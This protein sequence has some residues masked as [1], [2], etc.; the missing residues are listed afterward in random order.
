[1]EAT[2]K[3]IFTL[4]LALLMLFPLLTACMTS[5]DSPKQTTGGDTEPLDTADPFD[6]GIEKTDYKERTFRIMC[7]WP[8]HWGKDSYNVE[9]DSGD[10]VVSAIYKRNRE[11]EAYFNIT[12]ESFTEGSTGST[13]ADLQPLVV[14]N[15][16]KI[17]LVTVGFYQSGKPLILQDLV[18]P[19][20]YVESINLEK[21]W[22]NK[23]IT[24][25]LAILDQYYYLVGDVNWF[26]MPE[27]AV[28]YFNKVVADKYEAKVGDLYQTVRDNEWTYDRCFAL[29][30]E[31]SA[32][33]GDG[34]WD[35]NDQYCAIQ[36]RI[37]GTMG[38][39][40]SA[41]YQTVIMKDDGPN[42]NVMT[43]KLNTI[44][45]KAGEF[46]AQN[47]NSYLDIYDFASES[48]GIPIFFDNRALFLFDLLI[49][50]SDFR[51]EESDFDI[52]PYP[53]YDDKQTEYT[54]FAN[55]WSLS[56]AMPVTASDTTRTGNILEV[57][58]ALSR[59]YVVP[60]YYEKTLMGKIKR[61]DESE[62]MLNIIF[63]NIIYDFGVC[64]GIGSVPNFLID[65]GGTGLSNWYRRNESKIYG[66]AWDL[67][68]H[69]YKTVNGEEPEKPANR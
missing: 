68:A 37:C 30:K 34:K 20:N 31:I 10:S 28:C 26:Y 39:I 24:D 62:E 36:N 1:M 15:E 2:V 45:R 18:L 27:T 8:D 43:E 22:W 13:A 35:E 64:Y 21:D 6:H 65:E 51:S 57:M 58:S 14:S 48:K 49:H 60:A 42:M 41:D 38:F 17:D 50:A 4:F 52:I 3:R 7:P 5:E 44:L 47:H 12:I 33:N 63:Q 11:V 69:V 29:G 46:V 53:K 59:K 54:T 61:D 40:Y 56:C 9:E 19:W 16:D 32:D 55:Q 66:N 25:T 23:N 67:Y